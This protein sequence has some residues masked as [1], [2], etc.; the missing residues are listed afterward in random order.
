MSKNKI[1][2][3]VAFNITN[4]EDA[5]ILKSISRRNF[6]GYVKKLIKED[7]YTRNK[8]KAQNE[9]VAAIE[10]PIKQPRELTAVEKMAKMKEQ[11]KKTGNNNPGPRL[12]NQ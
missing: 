10:E 9:P 8:E 3:S 11:I 2:K 7:I 1:I 12:F 6:S 5:Q 4:E